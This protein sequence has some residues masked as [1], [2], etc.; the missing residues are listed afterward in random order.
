MRVH[1]LGSN[2]G[3]Y[4]WKV[5]T[6]G[7]F[8]GSLEVVIRT[9]GRHWNPLMAARL[10][11]RSSFDH[12]SS[13]N[14]V[15][16][17]TESPPPISFSLSLFHPPLPLPAWSLRAP[18]LSSTTYTRVRLRERER[19]RIVAVKSGKEG[20]RRKETGCW[21]RV[22]RRREREARAASRRHRW[23]V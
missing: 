10:V 4:T 1:N 2:G 3:P 5:E 18:F 15:T 8:S 12:V 17:L 13:R 6:R 7:L 20:G 22:A 23:P 21:Q 16:I 9:D 19:D 11:P 14:L